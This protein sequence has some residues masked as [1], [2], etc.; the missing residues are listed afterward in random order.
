MDSDILTGF[1]STGSPLAVQLFDA[2][3]DRLDPADFSPAGLGH[4]L[5]QANPGG[6]TLAPPPRSPAR[7]GSLT[8][9]TC[10]QQ[11]RIRTT[12]RRT[13]RFRLGHLKFLH[14]H[15]PDPGLRQQLLLGIAI[16]GDHGRLI[17]YD[18]GAGRL[19]GL[20]L[21]GVT[22]T[23][24]PL[25]RG[26]RHSRLQCLHS[27]GGSVG[28]RRPLPPSPSR[29]RPSSRHRVRSCYGRLLRLATRF[30]RLRHQRDD[31]YRRHHLSHRTVCY[32]AFCSSWSCSPVF[33][34]APHGTGGVQLTLS[35]SGIPSFAGDPSRHASSVTADGWVTGLPEHADRP[36]S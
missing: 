16:D 32:P 21:G 9:G 13:P 11:G 35:L 27:A 2:N 28:A 1:D 14:D 26:V 12:S 22:F 15:R 18:V 4:D 8:S 10:D 24:L 6:G 25:R 3:D 29:S 19:R 30:P 7:T 20:G 23:C 17:H 31:R 34:P 36:K 5:I 33:S